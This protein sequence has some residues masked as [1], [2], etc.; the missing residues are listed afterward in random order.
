MQRR[1]FI[2]LLGGGAA[3]AWPLA[4]R[5]QQATV[6]VVGLL[7]NTRADGFANLV[8]GLQ[9]GLSETGYVVGRN[10]ILEQRWAN[11][12][13]DRMPAIVTELIQKQVSVIVTNTLPA[14]AAMSVSTTVPIVFVTGTDPV[15]DGLVTSF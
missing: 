9:A 14:R 8:E 12:Q 7:R 3:A 1:K 2:T 4:T 5:A 11:E 13:H 10:V 6:P 15:R